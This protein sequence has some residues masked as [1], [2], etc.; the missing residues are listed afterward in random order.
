MTKQTKGPPF[1]CANGFS[2]LQAPA[3]ESVLAISMTLAALGYFHLTA[4]MRAQSASAGGGETI[5]FQRDG[6]T[7]QLRAVA[8]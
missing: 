2:K 6:R 1:F 5:E 7:D 8:I 3:P 4:G